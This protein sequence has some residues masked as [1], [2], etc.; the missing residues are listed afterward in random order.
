M[1]YE[2]TAVLRRAMVAGLITKA[3]VIEIL[4]HISGLNI[5][6]VLPN[7]ELHLSAIDW[8]KRLG[9]AK[10]YDAYYLSVAE[11]LRAELWIADRRLVNGARQASVGWV[12]WIGEE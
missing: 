7:I 10:T 9:Q 8:A 1:E 3:D 4:H 2:I 5:Q 12:H 11:Q 6:P